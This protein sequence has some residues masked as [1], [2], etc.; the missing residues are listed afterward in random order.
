MYAV[1]RTV[2]NTDAFHILTTDVQDAVHIRSKESSSMV[3]G[4]G[5]HLAFIKKQSLF[6]EGFT[7]SCGAGTDNGRILR[8]LGINVLHCFDGS[9]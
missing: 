7:V 4:D 8:Q 6:N 1:Y 3:M 9:F 2:F 5:F